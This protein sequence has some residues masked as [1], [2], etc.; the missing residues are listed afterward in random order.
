[1]FIL[2]NTNTITIILFLLINK[3]ENMFSNIIVENFNVSKAKSY[4]SNT[5]RMHYYISDNEIENV[6]SNVIVEIV[7]FRAK[8]YANKI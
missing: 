4:E 5:I 7:G 8:M 1:M 3:I 6:V 2:N